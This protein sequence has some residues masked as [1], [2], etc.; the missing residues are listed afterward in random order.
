MK[1]PSVLDSMLHSICSQGGDV[2]NR[3]NA[4]SDIALLLEKNSKGSDRDAVYEE[5]LSPTLMGIILNEEAKSEV[6]SLLAGQ[7]DR[8]SEG[9]LK[10]E[11]LWALGKT[12]GP[13]ASLAVNAILTCLALRSGDDT[14]TWQGIIS[15]DRLSYSI[16][17]AELKALRSNLEKVRELI[18]RSDHAENKRQA[19]H[20]FASLHDRGLI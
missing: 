8:E 14:E 10:I 6:V 16:A 4:I 17:A 15:L 7:L 18:N 5:L 20:V 19:A 1:E 3:R 13:S 11:L 9:G 2:N 12:D